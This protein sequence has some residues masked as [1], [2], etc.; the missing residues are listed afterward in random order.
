MKL[1]FICLQVVKHTHRNL[2]YILFFCPSP[3]ARQASPVCVLIHRHNLP[4]WDGS[5]TANHVP[6]RPK[7]K[8]NG[9]FAKWMNSLPGQQQRS[10][11][12]GAWHH[13]TSTRGRQRG[14]GGEAVNELC[15]EIW[16][17]RWCGTALKEAETQREQQHLAGQLSQADRQKSDARQ[18][19]TSGW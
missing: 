13:D 4:G 17:C 5:S 14:L 2:F 6:T 12:N 1:S 15:Q 19:R 18:K 8:A 3:C 7:S 16:S 9:T 11:D 10:G